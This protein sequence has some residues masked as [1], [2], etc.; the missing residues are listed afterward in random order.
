MTVARPFTPRLI[1]YL[2]GLGGSALGDAVYVVTL[3][4]AVFKVLG[5]Q[6]A[7]TLAH[8]LTAAFLPRFL[9]LLWGS[10]VDRL[11]LKVI[12]VV[13]GLTRLAMAAG[14]GA[15][16]LLGHASLPLIFGAVF[17]NGLLTVLSSTSGSVLVPQLVPK[18]ILTQTNSVLQAVNMGLP[19]LG[20]GLGGALVATTGVGPSLF[21]SALCFGVM[22]LVVLLMQFP[23][24]HR[25]SKRSQSLWHDVREGFSYLARQQVLLLLGLTALLVNMT[26]VVL[27]ITVPALMER[28]G[29]GAAGYGLYEIVLS[30]GMLLGVALSNLRPVKEGRLTNVYLGLLSVALGVCGGAASWLPLIYAGAALL[31][32][33]FGMLTVSVISYFQTVVPSA[34]L[35]RVMGTLNS[36]NAVGYIAGSLGT[37]AF[38]GV[39]SSSALFFVLSAIDA[40]LLLLLILL[41]KPSPMS[42]AATEGDCL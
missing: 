16:F 4:F 40:A 37:A 22:P 10:V 38:L 6:D 28:L 14:L 5:H 15:L 7:V 31:G 36:A 39:W 26:A 8:V 23:E 20:Y 12:F 42:S 25:T 3:P 32:V 34:F 21:V 9:G 30:A 29:R 2:V 13:S 27:N 18:A 24:R 17:L 33:G 19:L 41:A 1:L 35:G 11:D